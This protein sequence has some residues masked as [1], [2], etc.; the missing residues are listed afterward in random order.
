MYHNVNINRQGICDYNS[1]MS[2]GRPLA[3]A[4]V[5]ALLRKYA[6]PHNPY[7]LVNKHIHQY[8]K[9]CCDFIVS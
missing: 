4:F 5:A 3:S 2:V 9:L 7:T 8:T 1:G 6:H